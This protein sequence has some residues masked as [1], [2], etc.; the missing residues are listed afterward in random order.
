MAGTSAQLRMVAYDCSGTI[1]FDRTLH[2]G[3]SGGTVTAVS[4]MA[5][6]AVTAYLAPPKRR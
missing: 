6:D 2:Y 5:V 1:V 3:E 4:T